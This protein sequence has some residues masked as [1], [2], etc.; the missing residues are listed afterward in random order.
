MEL[1]QYFTPS[2]VAYNIL[3][4]TL[5]SAPNIKVFLDSSCGSGQL[6]RAA[7]EISSDA[8]CIGLDKSRKTIIQLKKEHPDWLLS[9]ADILL[10]KSY[11]QTHVFSNQPSS[12]LLVLNPPFSMQNKRFQC[13]DFDGHHIQCSV[14]M[15]HIIQ[16][17]KLFKPSNGAVIIIPESVL[18]SETDYIARKIFL[19]K[20][21]LTK[22][23]DLNNSTF[24]GANVHASAIRIK[25]RNKMLEPNISS[26]RSN[27]IENI[28]KVN[29][30][31]G[32]LPVHKQ[33]ES[34]TGVPFIH[35]TDLKKLAY[36]SFLTHITRRTS[37]IVAGNVD[38]YVIL[39]PRVGEPKPNYVKAIF[40]EKKVQVSDCIFVIQCESMEAAKAIEN[41]IHSSWR[42]FIQLYK[43]TA[44]RY[45][46][47]NRLK[48]WLWSIN[49]FSS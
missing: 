41:R 38:G 31:R 7:K 2:E 46:T 16:S 8:K 14:A 35:S 28:E 36:P 24:S 1:D 21:E 17:F 10:P 25:P 49:T 20:Y 3:S 12:D 42:A 18:Y 32:G 13:I 44:A 27:L 4:D 39:I 19:Q 30:V 29:L 9:T 33:K 11:K 23:S 43:G 47:I 6:L 37:Q 48:E 5:N 26:S 45:T 34:P 40:L 22:L 15:A